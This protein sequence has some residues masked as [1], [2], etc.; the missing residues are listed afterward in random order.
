MKRIIIMSALLLLSIT[1]FSQETTEFNQ[2]PNARYRLFKTSNIWN[3]IELNTANGKAYLI[4]YSINN[5]NAG[6][7]PINLTSLIDE[8]EKEIPGRFTLYATKNMYNFIMLDTFTGATYQ[9]QWSFEDE[10]R[11]V[12]PI[13]GSKE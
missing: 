5:G 10:Y 8:D 7:S 11:F 9:L 2:E 4:Q 3:F 13:S 1:L 6:A 12:I